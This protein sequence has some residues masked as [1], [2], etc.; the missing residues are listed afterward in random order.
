[1]NRGLTSITV[2]VFMQGVYDS[3]KK[4]DRLE[5]CG[6]WVIVICMVSQKGIYREHA[7]SV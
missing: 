6:I 1:M 3:Y 5:Y 7:S 2:F 4:F